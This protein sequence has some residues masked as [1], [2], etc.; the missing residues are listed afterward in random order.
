MNEYMRALLD[1]DVRSPIL[2]EALDYYYPG[3]QEAAIAE[4]DRGKKLELWRHYDKLC[5]PTICGF[6]YEVTPNGLLVGCGTLWPIHYLEGL[7]SGE[8][9]ELHISNTKFVRDDKI[10]LFRNEVD[11]SFTVKEFEALY[12]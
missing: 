6:K 12:R 9:R 1:P 10:N 11:Q 8:I 7:V 5:N 3:G 2:K 4:V